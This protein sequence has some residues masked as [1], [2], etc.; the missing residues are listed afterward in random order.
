[1][2]HTNA[3]DGRLEGHVHAHD[4]DISTLGDDAALDRSGADSPT[5]G[6]GEDVC[7][8]MSVG[9]F[10]TGDTAYLRWA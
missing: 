9:A 3:G 7:V 4:L 5:T 8:D 1:M 6:D 10:L 2:L